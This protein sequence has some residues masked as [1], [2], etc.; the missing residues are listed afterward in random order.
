MTL[1][2]LSDPRLDPFAGACAGCQWRLAAPGGDGLCVECLVEL[3]DAG[4]AADGVD[5]DL[6]L[7]A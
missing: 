2:D 6:E 1:P 5:E 7:A 3:A 4:P